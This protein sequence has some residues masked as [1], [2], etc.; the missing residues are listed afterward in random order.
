MPTMTL[1][2]GAQ[3]GRA[4]EAAAAARGVSVD[5]YLHR[6]LVEDSVRAHALWLAEHPGEAAAAAREAELVQAEI[7]AA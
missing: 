5:V 3:T 4:V 1:D 7:D 2:V 6:L